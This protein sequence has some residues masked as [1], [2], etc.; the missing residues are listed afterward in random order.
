[1][2]LQAYTRILEVDKEQNNQ[3]RE[4]LREDATD[5]RE[6]LRVNKV[7]RDTLGRQ[8]REFEEG[9]LRCISRITQSLASGVVTVIIGERDATPRFVIL[10]LVSDRLMS[11]ADEGVLEIYDEPHAHDELMSIDLSEAKGAKVNGDK[12]ALT[13]LIT[14]SNDRSK[15]RLCCI[16]Q[17]E[18]TKWR[19]ALELVGHRA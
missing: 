19:G 8:L 14:G 18:Y 2:S 12:R 10:R 3:Q 13:I 15:I 17:E 11:D 1:M 5:A 6:K 16:G 9:F 4:R 7:E